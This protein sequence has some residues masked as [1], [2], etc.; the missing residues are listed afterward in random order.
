MSNSLDADQV[1][2]FVGPD[3]GPNCS[4]R[5]SAEDTGYLGKEFKE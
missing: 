2:H 1:R 4:R 3:L 5:L